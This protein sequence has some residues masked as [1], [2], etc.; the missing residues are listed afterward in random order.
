M[1]VKHLLHCHL[2]LSMRQLR[3]LAAAQPLPALKKLLSWAL[4]A[5]LLQTGAEGWLCQQFG[6][7]QQHI[8]TAALAAL[9]AG[10]NPGSDY[11]LHADPVYVHLLRDRIILTDEAFADLTADEI[12][13]IL[14]TLNQHFAGQGM[15]FIAAGKH[16]YLRLQS[17]AEITTSF[18]EEALNADIQQHLPTGPESR[19]WHQRLNEVQML[20]HDHPVNQAREQRDA[21]PVNSLWISGGGVLPTVQASPFTGIW[22]NDALAAGLA[23]ASACPMFPAPDSADAWLA[24][25]PKG[26]ALVVPDAADDLEQEWFVPLTQ[27]LKSGHLQSLTLHLTE[28][29]QVQSLFIP[30]T[31]CWKF[32]CRAQP[33]DFAIHD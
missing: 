31:Q 21:L 17:P 9:G 13:A 15:E 30:R 33:L 2:K 4:P 11:W 27:A 28:P 5:T 22:A 25:H 10:V 18:R 20:L 14:D 29:R 19:L 12:A 23:V 1:K 16:C 32:W 7:A 8:P 3:M 24:Q 26:D 6:V